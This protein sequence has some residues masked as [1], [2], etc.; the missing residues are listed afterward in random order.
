MS[1]F[2]NQFVRLL[3]I[4]HLALTPLFGSGPL[5]RHNIS[6]EGAKDTVG[7][8]DFKYF[9]LVKYNN[10]STFTPNYV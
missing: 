3:E 5:A 7:F 4:E 8:A 6:K 1:V 9:N 10:R 2:N